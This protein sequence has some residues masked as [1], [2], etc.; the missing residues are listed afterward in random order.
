MK[1]ITSNEALEF[2]NE[3][4]YLVINSMRGSG[5]TNVLHKIIITNNDKTIG[6]RCHTLSHYHNHFNIYPHCKFISQSH[7]YFYGQCNQRFDIIL[8]D[9]IYIKPSKEIKTACVLTRR[10]VEF[11]LYPCKKM[12][13]RLDDLKHSLPA[14]DFEVEFG[15]FL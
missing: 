11:S 3:Y 13:D 4:G 10:H 9:E 7:G 5:K 1:Q 15:Q 6:I 14:H 8:G 2:F 12:I